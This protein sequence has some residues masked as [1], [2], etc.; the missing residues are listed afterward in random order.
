M[1]PAFAT[2]LDLNLLQEF[3]YVPL[4]IYRKSRHTIDTEA[5]AWL[6]FLTTDDPKVIMEIITKFPSFAPL[7]NDIFR[8]R[9]D[10]REVLHMFSEALREM[11]R[12]TVQYMIEQQQEVMEKQQKAIEEQQEEMKRQQDEIVKQQGALM[13]KDAEIAKLRKQLEVQK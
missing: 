12:N 4:D 13:E 7:Y 5:D 10:I 8:F 2:I 1:H 9:K 6:S 11:D 3:L